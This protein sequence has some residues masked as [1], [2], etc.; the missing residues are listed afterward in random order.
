MRLWNKGG[1][2]L[3]F[4]LILGAL[5]IFFGINQYRRKEYDPDEGVLDSII[6]TRIKSKQIEHLSAERTLKDAQYNYHNLPNDWAETELSQRARM[7]QLRLLI[8]NTMN[9]QRLSD[10]ALQHNL[11][12]SQLQDV[13]KDLLL[14]KG[15]LEL[16]SL[17]NQISQQKTW[18]EFSQQIEAAVR[19]KRLPQLNEV[20]SIQGDIDA[21]VKEIFE[22]EAAKEPGWEELLKDKR[23]D[24]Q[25]LRKLKN[26]RKR[27][28]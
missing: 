2:M 24:L 18:A 20:S 19:A 11:S 8:V 9:E 21:L 7:E 13:A 25:W 23:K 22:I 16:E 17:A 3:I 28:V 4:V 27:S 1:D 12:T 5:L 15:T 26:E 14:K 10:V 6:Q